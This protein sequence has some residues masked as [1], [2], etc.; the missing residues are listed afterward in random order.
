MAEYEFSGETFI[1][2]P[3]ELTVSTVSK[4]VTCVER[5]KVLYGH[6]IN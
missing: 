6:V 3:A 5:I 2:I 4:Y 1:P